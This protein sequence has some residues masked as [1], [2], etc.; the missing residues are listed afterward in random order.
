MLLKHEKISFLCSAM[1]SKRNLLEFTLY[2]WIPQYSGISVWNPGGSQ[3]HFVRIDHSWSLKLIYLYL[4]L[5]YV[6]VVLCLSVMV[7]IWTLEGI[8]KFIGLPKFIEEHV[9]SYLE[10]PPARA[11]WIC[12]FISHLSPFVWGHRWRCV[13]PELTKVVLGM[14][15]MKKSI[16]QSWISVWGKSCEI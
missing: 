9:C 7:K 6:F 16:N 10:C 15:C 3:H 1:G 12:V 4:V 8:Q 13:F 5:P 14:I 2:E 11:G